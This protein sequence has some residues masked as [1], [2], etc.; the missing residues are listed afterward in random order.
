MKKKLVIAGLMMG[1]MMGFTACGSETVK[2]IEE[3]NEVQI[4]INL[5]NKA[6][7]LVNQNNETNQNMDGA[8]DIPKEE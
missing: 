3:N 1:L 4:G 7:D 6:N 2:N 5:E 8:L